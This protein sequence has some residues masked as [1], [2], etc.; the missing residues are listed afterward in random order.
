MYTY[1]CAEYIPLLSAFT[2][3]TYICVYSRDRET[4]IYASL[5][6][7]YVAHIHDT[8][9]RVTCLTHTH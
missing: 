3:H 4:C 1:S 5:L 6:H 7:T 9:T 8:R 2:L